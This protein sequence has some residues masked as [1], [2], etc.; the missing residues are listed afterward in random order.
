VNRIVSCWW[1]FRTLGR[2]H[3]RR[4]RPFHSSCK[5]ELSIL[6]LVYFLAAQG[7]ISC[8]SLYQVQSKSVGRRVFHFENTIITPTWSCLMSHAHDSRLAHFLG[9]S[10]QWPHQEGYFEQKWDP[11]LSDP[12]QYSKEWFCRVERASCGGVTMTPFGHI[13]F[14]FWS[15]SASG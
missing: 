5:D 13:G 2:I 8:L 14:P 12:A 9:S 1:V 6:Y 3:H 7:T 10:Q 15:R 4:L 11:L